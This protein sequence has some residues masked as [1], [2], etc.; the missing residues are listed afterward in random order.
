MHILWSFPFSLTLY[1]PNTGAFYAY[2]SPH[3]RVRNL[4]TI[5]PLSSLLL[6]SS[7]NETAIVR[8]YHLDTQR[9]IPRVTLTQYV[10]RPT[11]TRRTRY[12]YQGIHV[13]WVNINKHSN[14]FDLCGRAGRS[15]DTS[16]L[17]SSLIRQLYYLFYRG[18]LSWS[19]IWILIWIHPHQR[20]Q[21]TGIR[22]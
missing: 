22:P 11:Y 18:N 20:P 12:A 21:P 14:H 1:T 9:A 16:C 6:M 8:V 7:L 15:I 4:T 10:I 19:L 13:C 2:P 5:R 17:F 3:S